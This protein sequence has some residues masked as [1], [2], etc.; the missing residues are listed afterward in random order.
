MTILIICVC[1]L[2]RYKP[3]ISDLTYRSPDPKFNVH[4]H[5][6]KSPQSDSTYKLRLYILGEHNCF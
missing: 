5:L 2:N 3:D 1:A 4:V 6:T